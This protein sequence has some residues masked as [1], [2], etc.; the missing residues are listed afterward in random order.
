MK[1]Y[2]EP[3]LILYA[4]DALDVTNDG[5]S[6]TIGGDNEI[7]LLDPIEGEQ[8]SEFDLSNGN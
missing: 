8:K 6:G 2:S 4:F 1:K 3:E 5:F 7:N